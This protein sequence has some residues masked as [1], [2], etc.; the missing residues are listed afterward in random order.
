MKTKYNDIL[1]KYEENYG[2][3]SIQIV[4]LKNFPTKKLKRTRF[5]ITPLFAQ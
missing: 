2:Y 4:Y 1:K 3:V 5:G